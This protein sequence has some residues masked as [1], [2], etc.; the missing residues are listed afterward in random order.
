MAPSR[1]LVSDHYPYL[2][3]A[4]GR[5]GWGSEV[6]ALFDTGYTSEVIVPA[7]VRLE[8]EPGTEPDD[9]HY[10]EV[11]DA[12]ILKAPVYAGNIKLG[13]FAALQVMI[14]T[15]GNEYVIG[16]RVIDRFRSTLDHGKRLII[17]P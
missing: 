15:L 1:S 8:L 13:D 11:G 12:R 17:E 6:M 3:V 16:R 5:R 7:S 2:A 4:I 14:L 10:V 9:Y